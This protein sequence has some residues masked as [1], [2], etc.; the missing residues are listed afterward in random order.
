MDLIPALEIERKGSGKKSSIKGFHHV[1]A[2]QAAINEN[3]KTAS[4]RS[5]ITSAKAQTVAKLVINVDD[6][7][8]EEQQNQQEEDTR[9][10]EEA[11]Q[12]EELR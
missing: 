1:M 7:E 3:E 4:L 2:E 9:L 11:A 12:E 10:E 6:S 8:E 5:S